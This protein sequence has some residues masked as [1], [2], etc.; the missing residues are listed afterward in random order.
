[1]RNPDPDVLPGRLRPERPEFN[2]DAANGHSGPPKG[3]NKHPAKENGA[4][5]ALRAA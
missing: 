2:F 4:E 5:I 3:P 1:M